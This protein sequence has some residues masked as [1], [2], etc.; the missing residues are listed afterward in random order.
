MIIHKGWINK[1]ASSNK[2]KFLSGF[3]PEKVN[4]FLLP[5]ALFNYLSTGSNKKIG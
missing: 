4:F 3:Y 1:K 5:L 2:K